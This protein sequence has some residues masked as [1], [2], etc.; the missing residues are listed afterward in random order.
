MAVYAW[1]RLVGDT[2]LEEAVRATERLRDLG[3][4]AGVDRMSPAVFL[5]FEAEDD[6][7]SNEVAWDLLDRTWPNWRECVFPKGAPIADPRSERD[8]QRKR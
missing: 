1:R 3:V 4:P 6:A 7:H 5:L 2:C 8:R